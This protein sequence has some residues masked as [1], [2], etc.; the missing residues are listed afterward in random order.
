M[1]AYSQIGLN[2][3]TS[4]QHVVA[5]ELGSFPI[6]VQSQVQGGALSPYGTI[7]DIPT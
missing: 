6:G 1:D 4:L 7:T 2:L 5:V 3:I